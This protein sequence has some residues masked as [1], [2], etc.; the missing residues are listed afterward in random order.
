MDDPGRAGQ[1]DR[2]HQ[3]TVVGLVNRSPVERAAALVLLEAPRSFLA[4]PE[5]LKWIAGAN[6]TAAF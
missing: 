3:A 6:K 5:P 1:P 2:E 4:Q